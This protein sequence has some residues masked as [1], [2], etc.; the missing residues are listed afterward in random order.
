[1]I[2]LVDREPSG[3]VVGLALNRPLDQPASSVSALALLYVGDPSAVAYWGGPMGE[4]AAVLAELTRVD[5]LEWFHLP[6]RERRPFPLPNVG[7]I[8]VAEHPEPFEGRIRRSRLY[9]GLC[10]W[11]TSQLE[12][13]LAD[14]VW[15]TASASTE[16]IFTTRPEHLWAEFAS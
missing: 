15:L 11:S 5:G 14:H 12:N 13:E 9:V 10:V 6:K 2:L 1:M 16:H 4:D 3:I 7:V 8:A